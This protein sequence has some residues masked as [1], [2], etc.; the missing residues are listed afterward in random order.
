MASLQKYL[1]DVVD[2]EKQIKYLNDC[3][4]INNKRDFV[5]A[6]KIQVKIY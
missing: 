4:E 3:A 5:A 6:R 1:T 2:L